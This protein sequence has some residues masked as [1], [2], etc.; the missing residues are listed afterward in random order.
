[1][2][3]LAFLLALVP[4]QASAVDGF[5]VLIG[6]PVPIEAGVGDDFPRYDVAAQCK[7]AWPGT[8][9]TGADAQ[10]VC[11]ERL[12]R[13]AGV[14]SMSWRGLSESARLDCVKRANVAGVGAYNVLFACVNL[15][16]FRRGAQQKSEHIA[17]EIRAQ[18]SAGR[19]GSIR[20][21]DNGLAASPVRT[22]P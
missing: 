7:T 5:S 10:A 3:R 14:T 9:P 19:G 17:S 1:M 18:T 20:V 11:V 22:S 8:S 13:I 15:A 6:P 16:A 21:G 12:N 2:K 4:A